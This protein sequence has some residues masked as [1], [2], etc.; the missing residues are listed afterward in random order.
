MAATLFLR[1]AAKLSA[2]IIFLWHSSSSRVVSFAPM[3]TP[4]RKFTLVR[5]RNAIVRAAAD[6]PSAPA[7]ASKKQLDFKRSYVNDY[8]RNASLMAFIAGAIAGSWWFTGKWWKLPLVFALPSMLYRL[9]VSR[10]DTEK[11]AQLS[12]SVDMKYVATSE[13]EL[14]EL[15]SFMCSECGYTLF[16]ARG[17]EAAFFTDNFKCPMCGAG[18]DAFFDESPAAADL[19]EEVTAPEAVKFVGLGE[20]DDDD[21]DEEPEVVKSTEKKA[22]K[23]GSTESEEPKAAQSTEKQAATAESTESEEPKAAESTEK[24]AATGGSTE[25]EEP[26]AAKSTEKEAATGGSTEKQAATGGSTK[27]EAESDSTQPES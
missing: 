2:A 22:A 20:D 8:L 18:K 24:Q 25:S 14:Q 12:A 17:R 16:P 27:S 10:M 4:S 23:G 15:H 26:K 21:D 9:W 19:G 7:D 11:L 1:R 5:Q 6:A 3:N 13:Q